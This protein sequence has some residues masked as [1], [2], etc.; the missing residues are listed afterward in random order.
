MNTRIWNRLKKSPQI[1]QDSFRRQ[2]I[3]YKRRIT[4]KQKH[5]FLR[6]RWFF[7]TELR[8]RFERSTIRLQQINPFTNLNYF[9]EK[10]HHLQTFS[11]KHNPIVFRNL[12]SSSLWAFNNPTM[13]PGTVKI[14]RS[15]KLFFRHHSANQMIHSWLSQIQ[16]TWLYTIYKELLYTQHSH[17]WSLIQALE[18][19]APLIL[20]KLGWAPSLQSASKLLK[21]SKVQINGYFTQNRWIITTPGDLYMC[22]QSP[23][24]HYKSFY[25]PSFK[26]SIFFQDS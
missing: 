16:Q 14:R 24:K 20:L 25:N 13:V 15:K 21:Q 23:K 6:H 19:Q 12:L 9:I 1:G 17:S 10:N 7:S 26:K 4:P 22:R 3:W 2:Q 5:T 18:N 8:Q 11:L